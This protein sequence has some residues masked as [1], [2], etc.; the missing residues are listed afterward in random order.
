SRSIAPKVIVDNHNKKIAPFYDATGAHA[1]ALLGDVLHDPFQTFLGD[2]EISKIE[3]NTIEKNKLSKEINQAF[4]K[5]KENVI[6]KNE[7]NYEAVFLPKD[8]LV[9]MGETRGSVSPVEVL[10]CNRYDYVGEMIKLTTS[11]NKELVVTPEHK[12]AI[13]RNGKTDYIEAKN[14]QKGDEV[15]AQVEDMIINEQDI[16]NIYDKRQQEQCKIYYQYQ[17][18]KQQ[19]PTW[20]YKRISKALG[21]PEAKTRWWHAKKHIPVPIQTANWLKEKGLLPLKIDNPKLPLIAKVLGATFGDGGIFDNLNGIFLSSS[22][23]EAVKEFGKD[24]EKIFSLYKNQNARIIEGGVYGHSWCYQ[25][26][27]RNIIYFFLALGAP[28]GNKTKIELNVPNWIKLST[29]SENEFYGSLLGGELGTPIIH[30]KGNYLTSLEL[31]ITGLPLFKENRISFLK[32]LAKYLGKNRVSTTSI[33]EGKYK[34]EGSLMFRLLIEKKIDN[35]LLFLMNIKINYCKYKTERLYKALGH[36]AMLKKK[37]YNELLQR[38]YGAEHAMKTLNLTPNS[39]Y[40][41]LNHFGSKE[42]EA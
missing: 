32:E 8:E 16:I 15:V 22:E 41:L 19:N 38:G 9:V 10:S 40:L 20:G 13:Q 6:K 31:G 28:R 36:W 7:K 29:G 25:N 12:I 35:V 11:E 26:T 17:E 34:T 18:L 42:A 37:K 1:G 3:R 24:L 2:L 39:L 5:H 30:K 27:N 23:K 4:L 33:Y 21:Q 14:I